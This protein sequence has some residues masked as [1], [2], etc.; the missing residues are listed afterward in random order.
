VNNKVHLACISLSELDCS[1]L[2]MADYEKLVIFVLAI[3]G[4]S[5]VVCSIIISSVTYIL[6]HFII[7]LPILCAHLFHKIQL[8]EAWKSRTAIL[9]A[10]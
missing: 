10:M 4:K 6:K 7:L 9:S 5:Y 2:Y 1:A 8:H 3:S